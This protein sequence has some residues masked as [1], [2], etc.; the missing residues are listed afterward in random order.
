MTTNPLARATSDPWAGGYAGDGLEL[1]L[2][3]DPAGAY[4]GRL[5]LGGQD[6]PV[7]AHPEGEGLLG[8]FSSGGQSFP[9]ALQRAGEVLQLESEGNLYQLTPQRP[10]NPLA[11][12]GGAPPPP[13]PPA[14]PPAGSSPPPTPSTARDTSNARRATSQ[15]V[16][17]QGWQSFRHQLGPEL[18][19]P[20]GWR[21]QEAE[22]GLALTP[23]DQAMQDGQPLEVFFVFGVPTEGVSRADDPRAVQ[24]VEA[25]VRQMFPFLSRQ[26]ELDRFVVGSGEGIALTL[27]GTNPQ[28]QLPIRARTYL[29]I[30]QDYG[31]ILLA[32]GESK[33]IQAREPVAQAIAE[34]FHMGQAKL[35]P[36]LA[37][38]WRHEEHYFSGEFSSTTLRYLT[39]R[40]DGRCFSS[41]RLLASMTH[42]DSGGDMTGSSTAD[43]G[44]PQGPDVDRGRW[45]AANKRLILIWD[46]GTQEVWDYHLEGNS[47][48]LK[49][50]S[51]GSK[52]KLY[53]RVG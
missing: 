52:N 27:T 3:R 26:G 38:Q 53:E 10:A 9:L 28:N 14:P 1:T 30:L 20:K 42:R 48:L 17:R 25:Q 7:E 49:P 8:S 18:R 4:T 24:F 2:E 41:G 34:S 21:V 23:H 37:G 40:A 39:L 44:D 31:L 15:G 13:P 32:V 22:G 45:T 46:D 5:R 16:D 33:R 29:A 43:T 35:D 11:R 36:A 6:F 19:Y 50:R 47:M 12:A 51:G